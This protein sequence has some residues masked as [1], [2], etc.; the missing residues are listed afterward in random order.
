MATKLEEAAS[1][2]ASDNNFSQHIY[3]S[4]VHINE[5]YFWS[6]ALSLIIFLMENHHL[7]YSIQNLNKY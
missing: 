1:L 5:G 7:F 6:Y 3:V 4:T 2:M